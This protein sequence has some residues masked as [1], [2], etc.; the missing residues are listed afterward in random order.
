MRH[1]PA[2]LEIYSCKQIDC[3]FSGPRLA[4]YADIP[5]L[6]QGFIPLISC[7]L[8]KVALC[9]ATFEEYKEFKKN[10]N[11]PATPHYTL[12]KWVSVTLKEPYIIDWRMPKKCPTCGYDLAVSKLYQHPSQYVAEGGII[13][14]LR[15]TSVN[16][17][18]EG[19]DWP[20]TVVVKNLKKEPTVQSNSLNEKAI[21]TGKIGNKVLFQS[22]ILILF[23]GIFIG[24]LILF[25]N[26]S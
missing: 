20:E 19:G 21:K 7:D 22:I 13:H 26:E 15:G 23:L 12:E 11:L 18:Y 6:T 8:K 5:D 16:E 17:R 10:P 25:L 14:L 9:Y 24:R 1:V 2:H 3:N 4:V